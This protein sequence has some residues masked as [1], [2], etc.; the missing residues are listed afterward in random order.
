MSRF[1]FQSFGEYRTLLEQ[2]TVTAEKV[3]G[4]HEGKSY[5]VILYCVTDERG[6]KL[7][8]PLK[9]SLFGKE[10][11]YNALQKHYELL[12]SA[13]EKKKMRENLRPVIV[14]AMQKVS[15]KEG[16]KYLMKEKRDWGC[17]S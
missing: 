16:L 12:K 13:V 9:S 11:G 3:G 7:G 1:Y 5:N 17:F 14:Q 4:T 10:V 8:R 15:S 2:F 6:N